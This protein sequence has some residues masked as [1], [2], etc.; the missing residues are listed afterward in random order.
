MKA[1]SELST[2][3]ESATITCVLAE[4]QRQAEKWKNS[5]VEK[6]EGF[7]CVLT[8]RWGIYRQPNYSILCNCLGEHICLSLASPKLKAGTEIKKAVSH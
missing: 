1:I 7:W 3:R 5:V 4:T 8:G 2:A 6:R